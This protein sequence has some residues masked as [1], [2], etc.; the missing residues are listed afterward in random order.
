MTI[1][2]NPNLDLS[3]RDLASEDASTTTTTANGD[4][5]KIVEPVERNPQL[6]RERSAQLTAELLTAAD[7]TQAQELRRRLVLLHLDAAESVARHYGGRGQDHQDLVQV[8][9]LGLVEAS[10]RYDP[11]LG[12]FLGFALPTMMGVIRRHFRDRAWSVK[13]P[14]CIQE[15]AAVVARAREDLTHELLRWPTV[16]ELAEYLS[17]TEDEVRAARQVDG[18]FQASSLDVPVGQRAESLGE[19]LSQVESRYDLV[20]T[21]LTLQ[22]AYRQL[23]ERDR[24]LV[25]LR[26]YSELSQREIADEFGVSQMQIS[27]WLVRVLRSLRQYLSEDD[28]QVPLAS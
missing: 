20:E 15:N 27:R 14:R 2:I 7:E 19:S 22:P 9:R 18:C 23:S 28:E 12:S 21:S 3:A 8:A 1:A 24:R 26:F 6:R 4:L 5:D 25:Y 10:V 11:S 17:L 16:S 13:P